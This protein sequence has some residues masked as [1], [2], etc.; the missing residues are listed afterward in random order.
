MSNSDI[1]V[2]ETELAELRAAQLG[3]RRRIRNL[4][5]TFRR[6]EER[7]ARFGCTPN[8]L[9]QAVAVFVLSNYNHERASLF[10]CVRAKARLTGCRDD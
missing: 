10:F 1:N 9:K 2:L 4:Q 5:R 7:E 8:L 3:L 6:G